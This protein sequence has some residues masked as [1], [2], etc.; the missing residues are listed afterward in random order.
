MW[1][2]R[3]PGRIDARLDTL[4]AENTRLFAEL[5][6][7]QHRFRGLARGVWRVQEDE[8]RRLARELH[9]ELGQALTA[10]V[11]RLEQLP[12]HER[13]AC[14]PLARKTLEDVRELSR[15]LRPPVLDDL[16][17][18]AALNWLARRTRE[19]AGLPVTVRAPDTLQRLD[20]ETETLVFRIAQEALTNALRHAA[21]SRVEIYLARAGNLLE[22]RIRDDGCGFDPEAMRRRED[23]GVGLTGMQDRLALF[24]GQLVVSSAAGRGTT[25]SATL[26]VTIHPERTR[27]SP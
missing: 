3:K 20:D 18:V 22:L 10:L 8:R 2:R 19:T 12:E 7:M 4:A 23:R 27:R 1:W 14:V 11:H 21:A 26:P 24:G 15:L 17:L 5:E 6:Q 16:G 13:E 25:I 9:D